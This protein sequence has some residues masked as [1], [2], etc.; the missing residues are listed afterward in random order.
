[1]LRVLGSRHRAHNDDRVQSGLQQSG[2]GRV[3]SADASCKGPAVALNQ[4]TFLDA[5]L[6]ISSCCG[7]TGWGQHTGPAPLFTDAAS[8]NAAR[9]AEAP[10]SRLPVPVHAL[11]VV[12]L[13]EQD[14]PQ[15]VEDAFVLPAGKGT[16]DAAVVAE[17][18][19]QVVPLAPCPHPVDDAVEGLALIAALAACFG[20][21]V[22][23]GQYLL[24]Q[25]NGGPN[26]GSGAFQIVG[27]GFLGAFGSACGSMPRSLADY[28]RKLSL[29]FEIHSK[30]HNS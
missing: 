7:R 11:K 19:G 24:D 23:D 25:L 15:D 22:I 12:A 1:M 5:R 13:G 14:G 28:R 29:R 2:V 10:I 21:R 27:N 16:V 9:F 8:G 20:R 30:L 17:L 3:G 4:H 6:R 26:S 18:L